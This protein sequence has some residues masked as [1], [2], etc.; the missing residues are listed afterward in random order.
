MRVYFM[1]HVHYKLLCFSN[2]LEWSVAIFID[3]LLRNLLIS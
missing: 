2:K 1:T 3:V